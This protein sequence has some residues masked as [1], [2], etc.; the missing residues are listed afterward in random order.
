MLAVGQPSHCGHPCVGG[1]GS[2]NGLCSWEPGRLKGH[3]FWPDLR[4]GHHR[5]P[6]M[7]NPHFLR[8]LRGQSQSVEAPERQTFSQTKAGSS[9]T[10][11]P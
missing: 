6:E 7:S 4:L 1:L 3:L 9:S 8:A 2:R 10:E 5:L 11:C